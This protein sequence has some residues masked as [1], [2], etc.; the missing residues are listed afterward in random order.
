MITYSYT[1]CYERGHRGVLTSRCRISAGYNPWELSVVRPVF[2][3]VIALW[4]TGCERS[5]ITEG[6][7]L[8]L[9]LQC[10]RQA[11]IQHVAGVAQ[12][13]IYTINLIL[14]NGYEI[15]ELP[16][17][18]CHVVGLDCLIGMDVISMCDFAITSGDIYMRHTIQTPSTHITDYVREPR[19]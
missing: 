10:V 16:V 2:E 18:G 14:P 9:G 1:M 17:S 19:P 4:D 15:V 12:V 8:K 3:E 6:L 5:M 13:N 7:A 11:Y